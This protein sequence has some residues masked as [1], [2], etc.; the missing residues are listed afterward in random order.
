[1][2]LIVLDR[3]T[4]ANF[5]S[6]TSEVTI[7]FPPGGFIYLTG[8]NQLDPSLGSNG[9]GKSTVWDALTWCLYGTTIRGQR[10]SDVT[11]WGSTARPCVI[12]RYFVDGT[13]HIVY[14]LGTPDT[15]T[16][17]G[18]VVP[19]QAVDELMGLTREQFVHSVIFGQASAL[20][21]D[22]TVSARGDMLAE[23]MDLDYWQRMVDFTA[24][25]SRALA[26]E[27]DHTSASVSYLRGKRDGYKLQLA[28]L[29]EDEQAWNASLADMLTYARTR[30]AEAKRTMDDATTTLMVLEAAAGDVDDVRP[31]ADECQRL[32][33]RMEE[34]KVEHAL[35]NARCRDT[36]GQAEF[37]ANNDVCPTCRQPIT[38]GA[39]KRHE[40]NT[41]VGE[42]RI[43]ISAVKE[44]WFEVDQ[45]LADATTQYDVAV[46]QAANARSALVIAGSE[47]VSAS[48]AYNAA[49]HQLRDTES[50]ANPYLSSM[51]DLNDSLEQVEDELE[52]QE[53]SLTAMKNRQNMLT[54]W[55]RGFG[56]VRLFVVKRLLS[57]LEVETA[58]AAASLGV[59]DWRI[60]F[61]TERE[62]KSGDVSKRLGVY[63]TATNPRAQGD[64]RSYS[65]GE[66]QRIKLAVSLG[67]GSLIQSLCGVYH[68]LEVFDEPTA[69]LSA[70]GVE[71]LLECLDSRAESTG[72]TVWLSD[73]H[74]LAYPFSETWQV[75]KTANGSDLRRIA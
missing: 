61:S 13:K 65:F 3:L 72:R 63:I 37:Y 17:D 60:S 19:Q 53:E 18:V 48:R 47:Q 12:A 55:R 30:T 52:E 45:A 74:S 49:L 7:E 70:E 62:T 24:E 35:L 9:S 75:T 50:T 5:R 54:F 4:I 2:R 16:I 31:L 42:L 68:S 6:F 40:C 29:I 33:K 39:H 1:M 34:L 71:D 73:H 41:E 44:E 25:Q 64:Y 46:Q 14:R 10:A 8:V 23:V 32:R 28:Q 20:F 26:T 57:V 38:D 56:M 67:L 69:W 66:T 51:N 59:G 21:M 22:L 27:Q 36:I 43:A 11:P 15:L 58:A